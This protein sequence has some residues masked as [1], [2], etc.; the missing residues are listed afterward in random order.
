MFRDDLN[1]LPIPIEEEPA[2]YVLNEII[3]FSADFDRFV[4]GGSGQHAQLIQDSRRAF[5]GLK[6]AIRKTAPLFVPFTKEEENPV[7][8]D[9]LDGDEE[10]E[11]SSNS[12]RITINLSDMRKHIKK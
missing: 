1:G 3:A 6:R 9:L 5:E 12:E 7:P 11:T 2:T 10:E 8:V 4:R